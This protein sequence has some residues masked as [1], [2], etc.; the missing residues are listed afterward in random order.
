MRRKTEKQIQIKEFKMK[1]K[2]R[3]KVSVS[4]DHHL[5][6]KKDVRKCR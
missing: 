3:Y 4:M 5:E 6:L 1:E 2:R